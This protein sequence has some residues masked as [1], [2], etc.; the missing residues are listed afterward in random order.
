M[1]VIPYYLKNAGHLRSRVTLKQC[2]SVNRIIQHVVL[3]DT[4]SILTGFKTH[5]NMARWLIL[6]FLIVAQFYRLQCQGESAMSTASAWMLLLSLFF[7]QN[8]KLRLLLLQHHIIRW[9][10]LVDCLLLA[11]T[12][13]GILLTCQLFIE[14]SSSSWKTQ[15]FTHLR[16]ARFPFSKVN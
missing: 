7:T 2:K 6:T 14:L 16:K 8:C 5:V 13:S 15:Q 10:H 1:T 4:C 3:E 9:N 11:E 12:L